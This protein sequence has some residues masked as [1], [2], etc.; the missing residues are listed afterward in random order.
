MDTLIASLEESLSETNNNND[1]SSALLQNQQSIEQQI[2]D[3]L[4]DSS[5]IC[6]PSCQE[7]KISEELKQKYL[8]AQTNLTTAPTQFEQARMNYYVY[9]VGETGYNQ[10]LEEELIEKSKKIV[11]QLTDLFNSEITNAKT[12]NSYLNNAS[13]NSQYTIDLLNT[14]LAK[15]KD[16]TN[17]L[18][19]SQS[20]IV[21][22]DRK[23]YYE[24]EAIDNLEL[25]YVLF[26]RAFYL[27]Y[28]I[29]LITL[30]TTGK[31]G[32]AVGSGIVLFFY[33]YYIN[34]LVKWLYSTITGLINKWPSNIYNNL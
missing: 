23:T 16:L 34:P 3:I 31:Y 12:M 14:Y 6:G 32:Y 24:S 20:D 17:Q 22:N 29:L 33:P 26:W 8:D 4:Q 15:N 19:E 18:R 21:T 11:K 28:I 2:N 7:K 10:I 27:L 5:I 13:I 9:T 25:W 1:D 30:I